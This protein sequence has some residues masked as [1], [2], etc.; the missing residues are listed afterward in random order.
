MTKANYADDLELLSNAPAQVESQ[1]Q[2]LEKAV[3]GTGL[4]Q[5]A[6]KKNGAHVLNKM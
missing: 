3:E 1:L 4:K 2:S 6:K 5:N